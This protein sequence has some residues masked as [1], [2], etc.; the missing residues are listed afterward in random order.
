MQRVFAN[1]TGLRISFQPVLHLVTGPRLNELVASN[2]EIR[3][4]N[5][6]F[7][8]HTLFDVFPRQMPVPFEFGR[9]ND[10]GG[11]VPAFQNHRQRLVPQDHSIAVQ[12]VGIQNRRSAAE[13]DGLLFEI[14]ME[15]DDL[16]RLTNL[17]C[18]GCSTDGHIEMRRLDWGSI[19]SCDGH[20]M[21]VPIEFGGLTS[22]GRGSLSSVHQHA[23]PRIA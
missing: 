15:L 14:C 11:N 19:H 21:P 1:L 22:A 10:N 17:I 20:A 4:A 18:P 3:R 5:L 2:R 9:C 7:T 8:D 16:G 6:N 23:L 12:L 13:L